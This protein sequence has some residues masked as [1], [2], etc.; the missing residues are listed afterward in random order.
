MKRITL[1]DK[2]FKPFISTP[3]IENATK[4]V[5]VGLNEKYKHETEPVLFV[6]VLNGASIYASNLFT[7]LKFPVLFDTVKVSSYNRTERG[8]IKFVKRPDNPF[9]GKKVIIVEDIIDTGYTI[10]YLKS[11]FECE[12]AADVAVAALLIK[13]HV[14]MKRHPEFS[15]W[16]HIAG[17]N[18]DN[19]YIGISI[20]D[21]FVVGYGLDYDGLG[22]NLNKIYILD[23]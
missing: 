3:H 18:K 10:D 11:Y 7:K 15:I 22:R 17:D 13:P 14:Y 16:G 4:N 6:T 23:E 1:K 21:K 12:G 5:A 2:K 8:D 20:E 19:M 9:R